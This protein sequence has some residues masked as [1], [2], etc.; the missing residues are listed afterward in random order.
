MDGT[1][2][3]AMEPGDLGEWLTRINLPKDVQNLLFGVPF[4]FHDPSRIAHLVAIGVDRELGVTSPPCAIAAHFPF[5]I[6]EVDWLHPVAYRRT[7]F[8]MWSYDAGLH[9]KSRHHSSL[10]CSPVLADR[11]NFPDLHFQELLLFTTFPR[12]SA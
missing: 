1:G 8:S 4:A 7:S 11:S 5:P 2:G 10:G 3:N 9:P 6:D 12:G